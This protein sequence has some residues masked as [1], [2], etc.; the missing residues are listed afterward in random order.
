M[1]R[2]NT[3]TPHRP[4]PDRR[5]AERSGR[6]AEIIVMIWLLVRWHQILAW[7][8]KCA[9]GEI[10]LVARRRNT[11]SFVEVKFRRQMD[12][13]AVPSG[14][15]QQRIV[16][17]AEQLADSSVYHVILNGGLIWYRLAGHLQ[18]TLGFYAIFRMPGMPRPAKTAFADLDRW[19]GKRQIDP[20]DASDRIH[21]A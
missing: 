17:A 18:R 7:R 3:T 1:S 14:R 21:T 20:I 9:S 15:Q 12:G 6:M 19:R 10:D 2:Q 11:V 8:W 4:H 13:L 5:R 16:R